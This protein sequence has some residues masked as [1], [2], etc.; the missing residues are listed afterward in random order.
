M[1]LRRLARTFKVGP[2]KLPTRLKAF[3]RRGGPLCQR[4]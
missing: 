1:I 3:S 4:V 2:L